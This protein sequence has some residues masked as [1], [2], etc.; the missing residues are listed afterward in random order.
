MSFLKKIIKKLLLIFSDLFFPEY[1]FH[2]KFNA[3]IIGNDA[4]SMSSN[5]HYF[6]GYYDIDPVSKD[7]KDLLCHKVS[8]D[9]TNDILPL[10]GEIG[11]LSIKTNEFKKLANTKALNWQL[12]SRVQ[13]LDDSHIIYNDISNDFHVSRK[14]NI[15]TKDIIKEYPRSFW[16][17]SPNKK[18]SASLNFSRI[19]QKRPGYGYKGKSIDGDQEVFSI[20]NL[21]SGKDEVK[22]N[23][24]EILNNIEYN[25]DGEDPYLNHV[26]WS[27]CS[28]KLLTIFHIAEQKNLPRRIYPVLFDLISQSWSVLD[29]SGFFSHHVWIDSNNLLAYKSVDN[30]K[31]YYLRNSNNEWTRIN[32]GMSKKDGHPSPVINGT[33]IIHDEYPN[34]LGIMKLNIGSINNT[35]KHRT[36]GYI[37]N[38]PEYNGPIRCD[39]HPRVSKDNTKVIC[40]MPTKLGRRIL[41]I[42]GN[43][44]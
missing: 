19:R 43:Y 3:T 20:F 23:L 5:C 31:N 34:K 15:H 37:K 9:Y 2:N 27:P 24:Q 14:L 35:Q 39:L 38:P 25:L 28:S 7:S 4:Q 13:W 44:A 22:F 12:G 10:E 33:D 26:A 42:E 1:R 18:L 40:D 21:E 32:I 16:A 36:I 29:D 17:I 11:L 41:V 30:K 8:G 6:V